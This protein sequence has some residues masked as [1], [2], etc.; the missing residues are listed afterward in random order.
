VE[1]FP[2]FNNSAHDPQAILGGNEFFQIL[3]CNDALLESARAELPAA[4]LVVQQSE[5]EH[6]LVAIAAH[7][8]QLRVFS[9]V[10]DQRLEHPVILRVMVEE[11]PKE[12][13][14]ITQG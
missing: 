3:P 10:L 5:H 2:L 14:P 9:Q 13:A 11:L 6:T 4:T 12:E 1:V 8:T 7:L